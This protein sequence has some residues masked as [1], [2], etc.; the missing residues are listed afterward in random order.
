MKNHKYY[1]THITTHVD[2][3]PHRVTC[4]TV[5]RYA[6]PLCTGSTGALVVKVV[7]LGYSPYPSPVWLLRART[8]WLA[9]SHQ[10]TMP[11]T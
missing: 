9:V 3:H 8:R 4:V 11:G 1:S 10:Q 7:G 2:K 5:K 6:R